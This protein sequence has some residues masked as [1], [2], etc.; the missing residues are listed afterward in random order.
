MRDKTH[1]ESVERWAEFMQ[2]NPDKWKAIHT[3]FIDSQFQKHKDFLKKLK[4][5]KGGKEKII[6]LY[7]IKNLKGY[8]KLLK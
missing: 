7:R 6:Q 8:K 5:T 2:K 4:K 1:M 3:D